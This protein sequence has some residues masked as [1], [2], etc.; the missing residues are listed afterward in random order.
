MAISKKFLKSKPVCK[1]RFEV[2]KTQIENGETIYLV[3]DF[4]DW[5]ISSMP[6]KRLKS[7]NYAVT[8]DLEVGHDYKFRYLAGESIWFNDSEADGF[9]ATPYGDGE[10][11]IVSL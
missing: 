1:V 6:M 4:N 5:D 9:E 7:G 3:G 2:P 8:V 10:N 11:S